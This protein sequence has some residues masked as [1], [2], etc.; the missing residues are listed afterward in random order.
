MKGHDKRGEASERTI[1]SAGKERNAEE[2][3][4]PIHAAMQQHV[5]KAKRRMSQKQTVKEDG[6]NPWVLHTRKK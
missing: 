4:K 2:G 3:R 6:G 1:H 5:R